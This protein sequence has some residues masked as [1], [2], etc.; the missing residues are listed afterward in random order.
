MVTCRL[1][2]VMFA[3]LAVACADNSTPDLNSGPLVQVAASTSTSGAYQID[4]LAHTSTLTQGT[5]DLEYIVT[6]AADGSPVDGLM[7]TIVPWMPAMGHGTPI[8]PTISALGSGTYSLTDI[9]L[10]M[11]GL[12]QLRT[13]TTDASSTTDQVGPTMQIQ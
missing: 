9:D 5:Y 11:A 13:T 6:S 8:V 3:V 7:M 4:V 1:G 2:G 12:W 10:F